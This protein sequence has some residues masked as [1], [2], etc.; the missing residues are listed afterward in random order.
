M[1]QAAEILTIVKRIHRVAIQLIWLLIKPVV[2]SLLDQ[3]E[4]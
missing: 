3:E 1:T 2:T 4:T